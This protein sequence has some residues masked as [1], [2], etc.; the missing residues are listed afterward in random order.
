MSKKFVL[1]L[2]SGGIRGFVHLGV[3]QALFESDIK[4]DALYGTSVGSLVGAFIADGWA[5][6]KLINLALNISSTEFVDFVFPYNGYIGGQKLN[7]YI[8]THI[9]S[10]NIEELALPLTITAVRTRTGQLEYFQRGL[11]ADR[12][13]ASCSIP[14]VFRPVLI[15]GVEYLDGDLC[16]PVPIKK[17]R[18]EHQDSV[19]LAV[20]IIPQ[21]HDAPR[22]DL[23]WA[24]EISR[25][26]YRQTLVANEKVDA[27]LFL[28]PV[29]GYGV[30]FSKKDSEKRIELGYQQTRA[31]IPK[32]KQILASV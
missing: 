5:P 15:D 4:I 24:K 2:G 17:A 7:R 26:I 6:D 18:E 16:S 8:K 1:S 30:K 31:L 29:L 27:D 9:K 20:D 12:I 3:Y 23:K 28:N 32:L 19:I 14:N 25:T 11:L 22:N 21:A 13:Q 10:K